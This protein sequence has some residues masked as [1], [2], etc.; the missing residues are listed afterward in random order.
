[1]IDT[2][3]VRRDSVSAAEW[4]RGL[5]R[6]RPDTVMRLAPNESEDEA[7][8]VTDDSFVIILARLPRRLSSSDSEAT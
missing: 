8:L 4:T 6:E 3:S 5:Q 2:L 7:L 1:M